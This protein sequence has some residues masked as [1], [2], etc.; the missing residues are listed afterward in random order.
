MVI[1]SKRL[2]ILLSHAIF[3]G[4]F[5]FPLFGT[6]GYAEPVFSVKSDNEPFNEVLARIS[7]STRYK[8]EITKGYK[9]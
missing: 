6:V 3:I 1:N 8:I 2:F 5:L 4:V 7:K 9:N